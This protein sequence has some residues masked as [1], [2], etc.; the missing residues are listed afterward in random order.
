MRQIAT[1][2][3]IATPAVGAALPELRQLGAFENIFAAYNEEASTTFTLMAEL[4]GDI[5]KAGV[6]RALAAVQARHPLLSVGIRRD[7]TGRRTFVRSLRPIP[8]NELPSTAVPWELAAGLEIRRRFDVEE[9]PLMQAAFRF[10]AKSVRMFFTFNHS[11]AD[12]TSGAFVIRDFVRALSGEGLGSFLDA[13][14]LDRRLTCV[15]RAEPIGPE[16]GSIA[17]D[18]NAVKRWG[19]GMS[20]MPVV[21]S[22]ALAP[23]FT[24]RLREVA[25]FHDATVHSALLA[26]LARAMGEARDSAHPIKVMSPINLRRMLGVDDECGLFISGGTTLLEAAGNSFWD[27]ARGGRTALEHFMNGDTAHAMIGGMAAFRELDDSPAG[28]RAAFAVGFDFDAMLTNLGMLP[29]AARHG[30]YRIKAI[31]G[32]IVLASVENEHIIGA[33]TLDDRL[34]LTYTSVT[35]LPRLL[36]RMEKRLVEACAGW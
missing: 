4:E 27:E 3:E 5:T 21:S 34:Q 22:L 16:P 1:A 31:A 13:D 8:L 36:G 19:R 11:I 14:P 12:G 25:R 24:R 35:P 26:A 32:P 33:A 30:R 28:A 18:P 2:H 10:E 29:I 17:P 7:A 23:D 20:A 15:P 6:M 9:G